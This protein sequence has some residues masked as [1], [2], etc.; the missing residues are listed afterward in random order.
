MDK[1]SYNKLVWDG[2]IGPWFS[3][4]QTVD[5]PNSTGQSARRTLESYAVGVEVFLTNRYY[6]SLGY[7]NYV[8][9]SS[10]TRAD[11]NR[12]RPGNYQFQTINNQ[13][14]YTSAIVDLMDNYNQRSQYGVTATR[15]DLRFPQ[16]NV[17]GIPITTIQQQMKGTRNWSQLRDKLAN[18]APGQATQIRELFNNW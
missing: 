9:L 8:Y 14:F 10:N 17:S 18:S 11:R 15:P 2:W 16:D 6:R 12:N 3:S 4:S 13:P 5:S 7:S 1:S